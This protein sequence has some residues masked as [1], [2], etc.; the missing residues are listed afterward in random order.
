MKIAHILLIHMVKKHKQIVI[1]LETY[2][3]L[4]NL[5]TMRDTFDSVITRLMADAEKWKIVET[6]FLKDL[7]PMA[8]K[9]QNYRFILQWFKDKGL[10]E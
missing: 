8:Q 2:E 9:S 6:G 3:A 1:R 5:G 4:M 10:I 7:P